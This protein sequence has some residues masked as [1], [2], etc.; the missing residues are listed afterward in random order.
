[1]RTR[2]LALF[3]LFMILAARADLPGQADRQPGFYNIDKEIKVEALITDLRFEPRYKDNVSFLMLSI[4]AAGSG[5]N[6]VVEVSPA[7][8]FSQDLHKG[9]R[10]R[11]V[12]SLA[13][14]SGGHP[15]IIAREIR[16]RGEAVSLRDK[17]GFPMWRG[18]ARQKRGPGRDGL[19]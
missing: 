19:F 16:F 7:S 1:M 15:V 13:G 8:F 12:G 5:Q 4:Q 10:I 6:Y 9:E 14:E 11:I 3:A 18:S 2:N 17:K